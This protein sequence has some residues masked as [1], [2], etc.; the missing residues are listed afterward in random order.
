MVRGE[1]MVGISFVATVLAVAWLMGRVTAERREA[2]ELVAKQSAKQALASERLRIAR[3]L[4]DIVAHGMSLIA[5]K[6]A[7]ANH[8][9]PDRPEET[10]EALRVIEKASRDALAEL[11]RMLGVLRSDDQGKPTETGPTPS[12]ADLPGLVERAAQAGVRA[13]LDVNLT[14]RLPEGVSLAV[15]R[16]V[17]EAVTNVIKHAAP[18]R[19]RI[20]VSA[21]DGNQIR[22]TVT[23]DGPGERTLPASIASTGHGLVGMRERV[24][25]YGGELRAGPG[26]DGGFTVVAELPCAP[27]EVPA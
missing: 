3:E 14:E 27:A 9:A 6:A 15:Y 25:V 21:G 20:R 23:D 1:A 5:V 8:V 19:C 18:A 11:R 7:V 24:L 12:I 10:R 17:Q 13:E 22:V 26:P 16:I 2:V 4:H